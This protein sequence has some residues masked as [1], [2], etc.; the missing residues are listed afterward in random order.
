MKHY[1]LGF[2][3]NP[4]RTHVLLIRKDRPEWQAGRF[5]G[6][7][8]KVN[9]DYMEDFEAAMIREFKEETGI[10]TR[11][12][13]WSHFADMCADNWTVHCFAHYDLLARPV[14]PQQ[15]ETEKPFWISLGNVYELKPCAPGD[16]MM[17]SN[18]RWL[19]PLAL[20]C[21]EVHGKPW[22]VDIRYNSALPGL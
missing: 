21:G 6:V 11:F 19:I 15:G 22:S 18:L 10:D 5:N 4:Q 2:A 8:G 13:D 20:D 9:S 16:G 1:V 12:G 3:F 17:L 14:E 7:G